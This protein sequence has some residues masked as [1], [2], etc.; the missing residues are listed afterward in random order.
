[1]PAGSI[2]GRGEVFQEIFPCLIALC[3]PVLSQRGR[4][5]INLPSMAP[6]NL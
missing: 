5:G 2:P 1:M 3:Q 6:H 4:K